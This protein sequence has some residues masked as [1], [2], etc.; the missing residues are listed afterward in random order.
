M[1]HVIFPGVDS[2]LRL[3]RL[4]MEQIEDLANHAR[5][6][7]QSISQFPIADIDY[8]YTSR[9]TGEPA[10]GNRRRAYASRPLRSAR[11]GP[12]DFLLTLSIE[13]VQLMDELAERVGLDAFQA[14]SIDHSDISPF[15]INGLR[16]LNNR[17]NRNCVRPST[18]RD[19]LGP[20]QV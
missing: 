15:R 20:F 13:F 4:R 9:L 14:C 7:G 10:E 2:E 1:S 3:I 17:E 6:A 12:P 19:H 5:S 18:F 8:F 16:R 11:I